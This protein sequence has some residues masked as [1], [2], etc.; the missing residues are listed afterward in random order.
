MVSV[1]PPLLIKISG[2]FILAVF[3]FQT[4]GDWIW[5]AGVLHQTRQTWGGESDLWTRVSFSVHTPDLNHFCFPFKCSFIL[6]LMTFIV[7]RVRTQQFTRG[8]VSWRTTLWRWRRSDWNTKRG[9]RAQLSEKVEA[10]GTVQCTDWR[11]ADVAPHCC[12]SPL[13][14][15]R[16][17]PAEGPQTRQHRNAARHCAH[18]QIPHAGIWIPGKPPAT[19]P[20]PSWRY[21]QNE[22][23][24]S[25]CWCLL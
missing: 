24:L 17:L 19:S 10:D 9:R 8:G 16:S 5:E 1:S 18:G 14:P 7:F 3:S 25:N 4:V 15:R 2:V 11:V 20:L 13:F 22:E 6:L 21:H 12:T 23:L